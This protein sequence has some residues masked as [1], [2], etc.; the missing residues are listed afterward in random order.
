MHSVLRLTHLPIGINCSW[1]GLLLKSAITGRSRLSPVTALVLLVLEGRLLTGGQRFLARSLSTLCLSL[2]L[3]SRCGH[4]IRHAS[5]RVACSRPDAGGSSVPSLPVTSP[6]NV[7]AKE[8]G[9]VYLSCTDVGHCS[10]VIPYFGD[11]ALWQ[12]MSALLSTCCALELLCFFSFPQVQEG[13][14]H[15]S[16]ARV[17]LIWNCLHNSS[18]NV[19]DPIDDKDESNR[20]PSIDKLSNGDGK[21]KS[22]TWRLTTHHLHDLALLF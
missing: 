5:C 4:S 21:H 18:S 7:L 2:L 11:A 20:H 12:R 16:L 22:Q 9:E 14:K 3:L 17:E 8:D 15:G 19:G 6:H 13:T 10:V 1:C